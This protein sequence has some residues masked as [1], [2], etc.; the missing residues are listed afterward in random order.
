M[1]IQFPDNPSN[2]QLYPDTANGDAA[3]ENDRVYEWNASQGLWLIKQ[4]EKR[5]VWKYVDS[6]SSLQPGEFSYAGNR[7]W[8]DISTTNYWGD[9]I[10][11]NSVVSNWGSDDIVYDKQGDFSMSCWEYPLNQMRCANSVKGVT[12]QSLY[13][14]K[15]MRIEAYARPYDILKNMTYGKLYEI[16]V[17][18]LMNY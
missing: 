17:P 8:F 10:W 9:E 16:R 3:L 4:P 5:F 15:Y 2:N 11:D 6:S 18:G 13:G 7:A 14:S 1:A 12:M